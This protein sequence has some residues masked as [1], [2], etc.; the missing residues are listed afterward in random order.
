M[1]GYRCMLALVVVSLLVVAAVA[2]PMDAATRQ[3]TISFLGRGGGDYERLLN[4]LITSFE[5][6]HPG[7]KVKL[8]METGDFDT[9]L[10]TMIATG[11]APDVAFIDANTF[12]R[13]AAA[14]AL[15]NLSQLIEKGTSANR[16]DT[17]QYFPW[18]LNSL[19]YKGDLY[20][21]PYDGGPYAVFYNQDLFDEVGLAYPNDQW[22]VWDLQAAA[23]K[24]TLV[25]D[26]QI[27]RFGVDVNGW[28]FWLWVWAFGG[29][30]VSSDGKRCLLGEPAAMEGLQWIA[31]L[32]LKEKVMYNYAYPIDFSPGFENQ[33]VAMVTYGY[34]WV[35]NYR[36]A[37]RFRWDVAPI[38]KAKE[39]VGLAWYS[40]F[41]IPKG[42]RHVN[43]AWEFVRWLV[44][45]EANRAI[46]P[47]GV[48]LPAM[49]K[50]ATSPV[51]LESVPPRNNRA[52]F[53]FAAD[54]RTPPYNERFEE[55]QNQIMY[56]ELNRVWRGEESVQQAVSRIVPQVDKLLA[57]L[58]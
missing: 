20:A 1:K 39:R 9:K 57:S 26:G 40:G 34:W 48:A 45:E 50:V 42:A 55:M 36:K 3:I 18:A 54:V 32:M 24:L 12:R 29:E 33:G 6:T 43:E 30:V 25:K 4:Q 17:T 23:K 21:L 46:A 11:L 14:G 13:F 38:P 22:T 15:V 47:L 8:Q 35:A 37:A 7:I 5:A 52:W 51:F 10:M 27:R 28:S 53:Q 19:R 49:I 2:K 58:K 31:D 44:S 56:P 41:A 16:F